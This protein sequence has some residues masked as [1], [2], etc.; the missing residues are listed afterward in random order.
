MRRLILVAVACVAALLVP[1]PASAS[2]TTARDGV[3]V[4]APSATFDRPAGVLCDFPI[5]SEPIVD[6]VV[7]K[8]LDTY[9]DGTSKLEVYTGALIIRVT[10]TDTGAATDV[11]ASGTALIEYRPCGS[12][13]LNSTWYA[14]GPVLVGFREGR[15]DHPRGYYQF[16]GIYTINFA[17][18]GFKTVHMLVGTEHDVCLDIA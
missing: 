8:V 18:D 5:H 6:E 7:M 3:W 13:D 17:E 14:I 9:P 1:S 12:F 11:D 15:G 4:P 2:T 16:D 10:N